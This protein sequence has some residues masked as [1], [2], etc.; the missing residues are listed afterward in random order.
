MDSGKSRLT[1]VTVVVAAVALLLGCFAGIMVGG[2]GGYLIGQRAVRQVPAARF[3]RPTPAP[4][5]PNPRATPR[6]LHPTPRAPQTPEG[7]PTQSATGVG[8]QEVVAG[9]PAESAGL[10]PG[11]VITQLDDIRLDTNHK[12]SDLVAQHKPGDQVK[13]TLLRA[14]QSQTITATLGERVDNSGAAYL[15]VRYLDATVGPQATP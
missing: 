9:S 13:L 15:G 14:S 6:A 11:D 5:V 8:I 3:Q 7:A 12:L 2:V 10:R 4:F 1:A